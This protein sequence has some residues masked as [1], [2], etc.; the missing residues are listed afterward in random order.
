MG[1]GMQADAEKVWDAFNAK[2]QEKGINA[3]IDFEVYTG[4]EYK[5]KFMLMLSAREQVDIVNTYGLDF[6]NEV[7]NGTFAP[8]D[9]L[10]NEYGSG[11]LDN[12]EDWF[13]EYMKVDGVV[14]GIPTWQIN[15]TSNAI[16]LHKADAEKY[17]D[18]DALKQELNASNHITEEYMQVLDDYLKAMAADGVHYK[19]T[20]APFPRGYESL[21]SIAMIDYETGKISN[22]YETQDYYLR[23]KY[24]AKWYEDGF[25]REDVLSAGE[26]ENA[27]DIR[28]WAFND[29]NYT[30]TCEKG[31]SER[32]GEEMLAI[33]YERNNEWMGGKNGAGGTCITQ[34]C[35]NKEVA[36]Q[37]LNLLQTDSEMYNLL[38]YG[39]EGEHY[40]MAVDNVVKVPYTQQGGADDAYGLWKWI[41][42]NTKLAYATES[43]GAEYKE[44]VE[45]VNSTEKISPALGFVCDTSGLEDYVTQVNAVISKYDYALYQG[46]Y[47]KDWEKTYNEF[48]KELKE[49]GGKEIMEEI[50]KQYDAFLAGKK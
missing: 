31:F 9:D 30:I 41:I 42:G 29:C 14:Y 49:V 6:E 21:Y 20:R 3:E 40:T 4:S 22:F 18:I 16:L 43:E 19:T 23:C 50:Q 36:M 15:V 25:I 28:G 37:V 44:W 34:S 13:W 11:I 10:L 8:L 39:L 47:G 17:L 26:W 38:V 12:Y 1:P 24:A 46:A 32:A 7:A 48:I 45:K 2:L 27:F 35:E 33:P 5:E